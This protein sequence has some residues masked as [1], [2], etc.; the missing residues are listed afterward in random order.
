MLPSVMTPSRLYGNPR[1]KDKIEVAENFFDTLDFT[2][3]FENGEMGQ[4]CPNW[5]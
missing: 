4:K 1:G 2:F 5:P 3:P